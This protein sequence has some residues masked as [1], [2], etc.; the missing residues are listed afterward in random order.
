MEP[1]S[2]RRDQQMADLLAKWALA[3]PPT[4]VLTGL[5]LRAAISVLDMNTPH[6]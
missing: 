6:F 3:V 1:A 4:V 5:M 2:A